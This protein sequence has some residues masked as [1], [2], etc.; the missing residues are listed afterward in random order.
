MFSI[1]YAESVAD[2]LNDLRAF[3]RTRLLDRI[4]R[5]LS[6]EPT[7]QT[8]N[9]KIVIGL[10]APWDHEEPLWQ[11]RIDEFR[12]FYDVDEAGKRVIV[13]AIRRKPPHKTT[14]EIL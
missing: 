6:S 11:L 8:R 7:R 5:Q 12:V 10:Q 3:D 14:E 9:Q 1:E 13:R 2:D 4:D